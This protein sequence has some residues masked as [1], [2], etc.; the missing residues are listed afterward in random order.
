MDYCDI[1]VSLN[2]GSRKR[3]HGGV[4]S[5]Y[6]TS[7]ILPLV[8]GLSTGPR[9]LGHH[10]SMINQKIQNQCKSISSFLLFF[11]KLNIYLF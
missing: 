2:H 7:T 10:R 4:V 5:G 9:V 8:D 6:P 11:Y 1:V 3:E